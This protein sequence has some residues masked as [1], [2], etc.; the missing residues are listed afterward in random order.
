MI[1]SDPGKLKPSETRSSNLFL[2][3][4]MVVGVIAILVG[5]IIVFFVSPASSTPNNTAVSRTGLSIYSGATRIDLTKAEREALAKQSLINSQDFVLNPDF[6][7]YTIK[8]SDREIVL[9]Y[10]NQDLSKTGWLSYSQETLGDHGGNTYLK[11]NKIAV[12]IYYTGRSFINNNRALTKKI[13]P[14]DTVLMVMQGDAD[15]NKLPPKRQY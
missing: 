5:I 6:D 10:Y 7:L 14:E 13:T 12:V 8:G 2:L 3:A 9:S 1:T 4:L 11:N 15:F